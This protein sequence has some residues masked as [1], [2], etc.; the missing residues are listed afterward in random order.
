MRKC[1]GFASNPELLRIYNSALTIVE[2]IDKLFVDI[3]IGKDILKKYKKVTF[4]F[5][6]PQNELV[7]GAVTKDENFPLMKV[8]PPPLFTNLSDNIKPIATKSRR[9]S[10]ANCK[11][12]KEETARML[13]EGIIEPSV[14]P[15]RAEVLVTSNENHK[16]R[17]VIDYSETINIFTELDAYPMPNANE[18]VDKIS[19]YNYFST[20][21]LKSAYHQIPIKE[22]DRKYTAF[23]SDGQ[24][25][26][27]TR[28][29]FGITN[30]VSGF[31]RSIDKIILDENLSNTFAF[32]DNLT[33]CGGT[34]EEHDKNLRAFYETARKYNITFN[35]S[36]SIL[37]AT[38]ITLLG[39][40]ISNNKISPDYNR[41]KPLLE[42][43]PPSTLKAQK[44]IV[45]MFSY[46][47]KYVKNCQSHKF[48]CTD[49]CLLF[50]Y[51]SKISCL[52]LFIV[53][54]NVL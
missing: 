54:C 27:F 35:E 39:Y 4:N 3:I 24:L 12:I 17:L 9:H 7:I 16:K 13:K 20:L 43:P 44:R 46:Y 5:K 22:E 1:I 50:I 11:F 14:S 37:S 48:W 51:F 49:G 10:E 18:M 19:K 2:V 8:S 52:F 25:N 32:V 33:V 31:Q 23:E 38:S 30:G 45:G 29:P 36:K 53:L 42:M 6:G 26:Q 34:Q 15:W 40:T 41:L 28:I 47:S 21:D